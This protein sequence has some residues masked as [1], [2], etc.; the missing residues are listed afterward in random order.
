MQRY[1]DTLNRKHR[2]ETFCVRHTCVKHMLIL[3]VT[4]RPF[5][6]VLRLPIPV[7]LTPPLLRV[8]M[9]SKPKLLSVSEVYGAGIVLH[10]GPC[11][12]MSV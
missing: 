4:Y 11:P 8:P 9:L 6:V 7:I 10:A 12:G 5:G 3:A 2:P 1:L